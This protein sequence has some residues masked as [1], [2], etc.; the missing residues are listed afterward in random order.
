MK[1]FIN[2]ISKFT[3]RTELIFRIIRGYVEKKRQNIKKFANYLILHLGQIN[4]K[5]NQTI[6]LK[7]EEN[8]Y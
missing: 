8:S 5:I 4:T 6:L 1:C 7:V 3:S 2:I